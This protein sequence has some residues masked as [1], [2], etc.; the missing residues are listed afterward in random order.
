MASF[1]TKFTK[2]DLDTL[3]EAMGD[4]EMMGNHEWHTLNMIKQ[5]PLPPEDHE[6]HE[7]IKQIKEH[8]AQR[9]KDIVATRAIRQEKA[10]FVKAKL[11][12][13][14]QDLG[15]NQL[16]E[17]ATTTTPSSAPAPKEMPEKKVEK[18]VEDVVSPS[19]AT[20]A[21]TELKKKLELAEFFIRDLGVWPHYEKF[22]AEKSASE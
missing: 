1:D 11:M 15:I 14:R 3:V 10:V 13:A 7:A 19:V 2:E 16:F 4:W 5:V 6:A 21:I 17:M 8:F 20:D 18:K 22:L 9:E 12:L